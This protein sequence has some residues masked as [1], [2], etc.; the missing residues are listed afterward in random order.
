MPPDSENDR[1]SA[2]GRF[3]YGRSYARIPVQIVGDILGFGTVYGTRAVYRIHDG[4][5]RL[6]PSVGLVRKNIVLRG[7][8]RGTAT[9]GPAETRLLDFKNLVIT[10]V[11]EGVLPAGRSD[12]SFIPYDVKRHFSLPTYSEKDA[13]YSYHFFRLLQ[14]AENITV[15]YNTDEGAMGQQEPSRFLLQVKHDFRD[16]WH[17]TDS[18]AS[19]LP[20]APAER[21]T[22]VRKTPVRA[23]AHPRDTVERAFPVGT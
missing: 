3:G 7:T 21:I 11:N 10:G 4:V 18:G 13:V 8:S 16:K 6:F 17:I 2:S 15:V 20:S 14:R 5:F 19:F 9:Y 23:G 1:R 12:N 22:E